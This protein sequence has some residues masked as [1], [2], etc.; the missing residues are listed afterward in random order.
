MVFILYP[1]IPYIKSTRR[2]GPMAILWA[3]PGYGVHRVGRY[4]KSSEI[5][6]TVAAAPYRLSYGRIGDGRTAIV[7]RRPQVRNSSGT[8]SKRGRRQMA[9][10]AAR[11]GHG[12]RRSPV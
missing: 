10:H 11:A 8:L 12:W 6:S 9:R 4:P 1:P 5:A 3:R 7:P 2:D